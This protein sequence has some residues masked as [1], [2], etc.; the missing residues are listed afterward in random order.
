MSASGKGGES[1]FELDFD[2]ERYDDRVV[3]RDVMLPLVD[4]VA[5]LAIKKGAKP[6]DMLDYMDQRWVGDSVYGVK[7]WEYIDEDDH[8][9]TDLSIQKLIKEEEAPI[10][11]G[12]AKQEVLEHF[13]DLTATGP[14]GYRVWPDGNE[15][16]FYI[17]LSHTYMFCEDKLQST[18]H[19][20]LIWGLGD[21][22]GCVPFAT[23][24]RGESQ[25]E[26]TDE[27]LTPELRL[28]DLE[29]IESACYVFDAVDAAIAVRNM[30]GYDG[31]LGS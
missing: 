14:G 1:R 28:A 11:L 3:F 7:L 31:D 16:N 9:C 23:P 12:W 5:E 20:K 27:P 30:K 26:E 15:E 13:G 18:E 24:I 29:I 6:D 22:P 8:H 4:C 2:L 17:T 19:R 10:Y 25:N 21:E